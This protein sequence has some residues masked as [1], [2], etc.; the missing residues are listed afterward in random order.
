[1]N[2][3]GPVF[4]VLHSVLSIVAGSS[5]PRGLRHRSA[6]RLGTWLL[7]VAAASCVQAVTAIPDARAAEAV[8][9]RPP[10]TPRK[11]LDSF[12]EFGSELGKLGR[13]IGHGTVDAGKRAADKVRSDV[14]DRNFKPRPT[15]SP[16]ASR[17]GRGG[18]D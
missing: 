14:R 12:K 17:N 9:T 6:C 4:A 16:D 11:K 15:E 1:M 10:E 7:A 13:R 18:A 5:S 8:T 2:R 3:H